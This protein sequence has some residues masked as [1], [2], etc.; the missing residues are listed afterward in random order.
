MRRDARPFSIPTQRSPTASKHLLCDRGFCA[1]GSVAPR[2]G[3]Y[4]GGVL[5]S[6]ALGR[7]NRSA[8]HS[9]TYSKYR[10]T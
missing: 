10:G 8:T 7:P 4:Y 1:L 9:G 5:G 6:A 2:G 3:S